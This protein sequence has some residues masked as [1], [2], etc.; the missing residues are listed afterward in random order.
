MIRFSELLEGRRVA[1]FLGGAGSGKTEIALNFALGLRKETERRI[2][3]FDM[4]QTKP[5]FR[6]RDAADRLADAG[7]DFH[8][9]LDT[10]IED[11]AAIA[12]GVIAALEETDSYVILDIGGNEQGARVIG[13]FFQRLTRSD[14]VLFL[15][16]NPYR[17]WS[18]SPEE[19]RQMIEGIR[20]AARADCVRIVSNPN[21]CAETTA[22]DVAEGNEKLK[23]MLDGAYEISFVCAMAPLCGALEHRLR[24]RLIPI[25][26]QIRYPWMEETDPE[27]C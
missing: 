14:S 24:E 11:V 2:H 21:F 20:N 18:G 22:D 6:A 17:P 27:T 12:P 5:L 26:I 7:I 25:R 23:Q 1:A 13:Q 19:L 15:P 8:S 9:N 10:S 3:F 4:D 16:I